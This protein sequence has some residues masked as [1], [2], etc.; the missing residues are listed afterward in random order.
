MTPL[1]NYPKPIAE[2]WGLSGDL[3]A[4]F[5]WS[6]D[7]FIYFI[8][9]ILEDS[10]DESIIKIVHLCSFKRYIIFIYR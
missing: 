5:Q 9:G 4:A 3:D 7:G 2:H 6:Q 1:P 8:K 10:P